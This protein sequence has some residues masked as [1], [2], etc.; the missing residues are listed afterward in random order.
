M[1]VSHP[2]LVTCPCDG[3]GA[4]SEVD[5]DG[6]CISGFG[7]VPLL[8]V[9][10]GRLVTVDSGLVG[11]PGLKMIARRLAIVTVKAVV[12]VQTLMTQR[13]LI[14]ICVIRVVFS[15]EL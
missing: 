12:S 10:L 15:F 3:P 7:F 8:A 1:R 14:V 6:S 4:T 5:P 13:P 9:C 2:F 11:Y